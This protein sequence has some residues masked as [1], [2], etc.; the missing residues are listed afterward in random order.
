MKSGYLGLVVGLFSILLSPDCISQVINTVAGNGTG[1]YSGDGGLATSAQMF[2]PQDVAFDSKGNLYITESARIR[3]VDTSG[4]ITTIAGNGTTGFSGDGGPA[5]LCQLSFPTGIAFDSKGNLF[6]SDGNNSRIRKIDTV[7]TINTIAGNGTFGYSGDGGPASASVVYAPIGLAFDSKGNLYIGDWGNSRIRKID[8]AGIISTVA[9][10]GTGGFS[11]DGGP[12]IIAQLIYVTHIAFDFTGNMYFGDGSRIR[13]VDTAGIITTI[14]GTGIY[15][16]LGNGIPATLARLNFPF[17]LKVDF[18]GNLYF[19]DSSN[20]R[21]RKINTS[22]IITNVAGTGTA[23][24]GGDGGPALSALIDSPRGITFDA[25]GD[26]FIADNSNYRIRKITIPCSTPSVSVLGGNSS[27][28]QGESISISAQGAGSYT[29][30]PGGYT[31]SSIT[32]SPLAST[33]FTLVAATGTCSATFTTSVSL[34]PLPTV[35]LGADTNVCASPLLLTANSSDTSFVW[36]SGETTS[37]ITVTNSGSYWITVTN[38]QGCK[39]S[40]TINVGVFSPPLIDTLHDIQVCSNFPTAVSVDAT[41]SNTTSY[42]WNDGFSGPL[43]SISSPGVYWVDYTLSNSCISRDSFNLA[44]DSVPAIS[45]GRDTSLCNPYSLTADGS[46]PYLW[47]T[48]DT[49]QQIIVTASGSYLVIV[50]SPQG[51][52]NSDTVNVTVYTAP[53]INTLKDSVECGN[54]FTSLTVDAFYPNTVTYNW[55][56]GFSGQTHTLTSP[57]SYWVEYTL[58]NTCITRDSLNVVLYP[59]PLVDLGNDTT[60]CQGSISLSV[61]TSSLVYNWN[62][63]STTPGITVAESGIYWLDVN[64]M[65]CVSRDSVTVIRRCDSPV[66]NIPNIF[67]PNNDEINDV[68]LPQIINKSSI[69]DYDL[70]I[71]NRWGIELFKTEKTLE[72]WDART[73]AGIECTEGTYYY[74]ISYNDLSINKEIILKGFFELFR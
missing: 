42:T 36:S 41:Y 39:N 60:F 57:G 35:N 44:V 8:T 59:Y 33:T 48:G 28:C 38:P 4:I 69:K 34:D 5:T 17:G 6:F 47:N 7:G 65:G 2:T 67:T 1:G 70:I 50:T 56:D 19:A 61:P 46:G 3:K 64:L 52:K 13:K 15:A 74:V 30:N 45:L 55:S 25:N 12:A 20:D 54:I 23:G 68:W 31:S 32:V 29:W 40:D 62:T 58:A 53:V 21:I 16:Y 37:G 18:T 24:Y 27:I 71:F 73:T 14:A 10:N 66:I 63:G 11:G 72:G 26:L 9:G 49:T 51:C 43:H 22:G